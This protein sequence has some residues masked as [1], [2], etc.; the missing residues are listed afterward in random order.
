MSGE[1][2]IVH[3]AA[4]PIDLDH[5]LESIDEHLEALRLARQRTGLWYPLIDRLLD[6]RMMFM[7]PNPPVRRSA[8]PT[9][10]PT[11]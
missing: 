11:W 9:W 1:R 8:W 2:R 5:P 3:V 10:R 7:A 4:C 6:A